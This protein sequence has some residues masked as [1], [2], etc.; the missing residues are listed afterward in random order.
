RPAIALNPGYAEAHNNL[1]NVLANQGR[2][3]DAAASYRAAIA[4]SPELAE[5]HNNLGTALK[6]MGRLDEALVHCNRALAI[7]PD[8]AEAH[9]NMLLTALYEPAQTAQSLYDLHRQWDIRHGQR[10]AATSAPA[11]ARARDPA[12]PLR[13][14]YLSPD[15]RRHSVSCFLEPV[16]A[17]HDRQAFTIYCYS[18][19][20]QADEVT[21]RLR[22]HADNWRSVAGLADAAAARLIGDDEIDILVD[23]SGHTMAN[24]LPLFSLK[25]APVQVT[26]LGYPATT[27]LAAMDYRLTDAL[28]DPAGA[29]D[30]WHAEKLLRL[31][32]GFLC[33][34]PPADA[35]E[36]GPA[37]GL[38]NGYVTFGSC[39]N[40]AK[41]TAPTVAAWAQ[42][43]DGVPTSK[44]LIKAKAL[45]DAGVRDDLTARFTALGITADRLE[46]LPWISGASPL[47]VYNAIDI[48]L[49]TFP[50]T[51]TTTICETHWM[52][53][54]T[55]TLSGDRHAARVGHSLNARVGLEDWVSRSIDGYVARAVRAAAEPDLLTTLRR[56]LRARMA[57]GP[58]CNGAAFTRRL[59]AAYREMVAG[60]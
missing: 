51:G 55:L 31:E 40:L 10:P 24:R 16:L 41:I 23:L 58:L 28:A 12:R 50:Y 53:V 22:A 4:I 17:N 54:P 26:W 48:A 7:D 42:I 44:L 19:S 13:I 3:S 8:A 52:G 32:G 46:L 56:E 47:S 5:A 39:N 2:L 49:D 34:Q 11:A 45:E 37:P 35:P 27:G 30:A 9:S 25:P 21:A 38:K 59:E 14:G 33:Y 20:L 36:I 1:G 6:D 57:E 43:L 29:D 60:G 18:N 15:L